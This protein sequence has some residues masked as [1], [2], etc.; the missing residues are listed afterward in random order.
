MRHKICEPKSAKHQTHSAKPG[1][2]RY[3]DAFSSQHRLVGFGLAPI[4]ERSDEPIRGFFG[5]I[6]RLGAWVTVAAIL[7]GAGGSALTAQS[8]VLG[9]L[10]HASSQPDRERSDQQGKPHRHTGKADA[11]PAPATSPTAKPA[12]PTPSQDPS[13]RRDTPHGSPSKP[14]A[15]AAPTPSP[16]AKPVGPTAGQDSSQQRDKPHGSPGK[17]DGNSAPPASPTAYPVVPTIAEDPSSRAARAAT[18]VEKVEPTGDAVPVNATIV[19]TFSQ[20]MERATVERSFALQPVAAGQLTWADDFTL[21]FQPRRLAHSVTY[22][23][24]VGGRSVRGVLLRGQHQWRFTTLAL[25]PVVLSPLPP[26]ALE[27]PPSAVVRATYV[28]KVEPSGDAV[29]VNTAIVVTFSQPMGRSSVEQSFALWPAAAGR[30]S[31]ADDLT[32]R[33]QPYRL[34]HGVTY[35]VQVGGRSLRGVP[36]KGQHEWRFTTVAPPPVVLAPGP[37]SI[38]VPILMYHYIRVVTDPNDGMGFRLSV[39]PA[40]FAAQMGWLAANGYHPITLEDLNAYL[41]GTRGLPSKPVILTFDDGYADFYNTAL[42]ILRAHDFVAVEYVVSGFMGWPGYMSADQI[43]EANRVWGIEIGSHTATHVNLTTQSADGL[44]SQLTASKHALETLLG[45]PVLSF[46]YPGGRFNSSAMAAV[47][48]AGYRDATT[49]QPGLA[50]T[51]ADR[52]AWGRLRISGGESL[53][54]F[55]WAVANAS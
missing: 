4:E 47:Q 31:W 3:G 32:F 26:S 7:L 30:V 5:R 51:L 46:C 13:Q 22:D 6:A 25:P 18:Y 54:E 15:S 39:T 17:P 53:D 27:N 2:T 23:L 33:F 11:S 44:L 35:E 28:D 21:R 43:L 55:A 49:T 1:R 20:P 12:G 52:Y 38:K 42:P 29:S 14:D 19:L 36:L 24:Q 34:A 50:H 9:A 40:D 16:T 41:S 48:A 10:A 37:S 8:P 45:H